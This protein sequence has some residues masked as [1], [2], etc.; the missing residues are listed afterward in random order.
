MLFFPEPNWNLYL[1][2][3]DRDQDCDTSAAVTLTAFGESGDTGPLPLG[4]AGDENFQTG[5]TD[6]FQVSGV[7]RLSWGY[8]S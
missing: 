7:H 3:S 1:T 5:E 6:D 2:T 4:E 8:F